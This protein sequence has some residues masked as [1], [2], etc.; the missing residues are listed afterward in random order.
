MDFNW[1][2]HLFVLPW[3]HDRSQE[4]DEIEEKSVLNPFSLRFRGRASDPRGL[5]VLNEHDILSGMMPPY[6]DP[7]TLSLGAAHN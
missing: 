4:F 5:A 3:D 6:G 2:K 1:H 7:A